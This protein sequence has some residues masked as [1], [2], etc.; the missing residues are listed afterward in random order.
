MTR[1]LL[2]LAAVLISP[3]LFS[4]CAS[5]TSGKT[6]S[7]TLESVCGG[8]PVDGAQCELTNSKGRWIV[9]TPGSVAVHKA[10]GDLNISCTKEGFGAAG[11]TFESSANGG[12][13]GNIIAGGVVGY[14]IDA[15]SGAGFNYPETMTIVF[16]PPC[17]ESTADDVASTN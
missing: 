15:G 13:W 14:F 11:G 4:G 17:G 1:I 16:D 9:K 10:Y 3:L 8:D 12:A 2:Q 5:I 7:L 6:Q